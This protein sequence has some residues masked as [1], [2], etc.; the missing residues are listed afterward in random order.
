MLYRGTTSGGEIFFLMLGAS[1]VHLDFG[2]TSGQ[3]YFYK[4][5]AV[6][7]MGEGPKSNEASAKP[8]EP[9]PNQ[10]PTVFLEYPISGEVVF[11]A[12]Q[13][14]GRAYDSDGIVERVEVKIDDSS[15]GVALGT[16]IWAF[17]WNTSQFSDGLHTI[18]ARS[19][20]G[21]N[22]SNEVS[23][24]VTVDNEVEADDPYAMPSTFFILCTAAFLT[25]SIILL[26]VIFWLLK[27]MNRAREPEQ[28]ES[29]DLP[30]QEQE[31]E[32]PQ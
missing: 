30:E 11:G 26:I 24:T 13:I 4:V 18:Y 6:N 17:A 32:E 20:D 14:G 25:L 12:Y 7:V 3:D 22:Y 21:E 15:W 2:L 29:N 31:P 16:Q 5:S 28:P 1:T 19:Y 9:P 8:L 27:R 10:P 23:S